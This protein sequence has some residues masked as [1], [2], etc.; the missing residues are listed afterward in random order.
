MKRV[1]V[2]GVGGNVGQYL[3]KYLYENGY[4]V[5]GI[6]RN[7]IP[8]LELN[9]LL[10]MDLS[11]KELHMEAVDVIIH[12]AAS[13]VGKAE[14]LIEDNI[15]STKNLLRYA[16]EKAVKQF[17]YLSTVSVYGNVSGKLTVYSDIINPSLYG[18]TKYLAENL[19]KESKILDRMIVGL[20]RMLGPFVDL[21]NTKNS[22][23]LAMAKK[24]LLGENVACFIPNSHYNNFMHVEDLAKFLHGFITTVNSGYRKVLLGTDEELC[25]FDILQIMKEAVQSKSEIYK[26]KDELQTRNP[27]CALI[28]IQDAVEIGYH[29]MRAREVLRKFMVEMYNGVGM[30]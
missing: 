29:P 21:E 13:I 27:A 11:K 17:V 23:F 16:E 18:T 14:Q 19:V 2:T 30:K 24:I 4:Y 3:A 26:A 25:M 22:G 12:A 8:N 20:P 5:I 9:E 7:Q 1:L 28:S 6:Y 10:Q 15:N